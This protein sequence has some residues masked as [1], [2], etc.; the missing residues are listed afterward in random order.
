MGINATIKKENLIENSDIDGN[1]LVIS[2]GKICF[3]ST[4][5][6]G[7][8]TYLKSAG[9]IENDKIPLLGVNSD[10]TRRTGALL[11]KTINFDKK[12]EIIP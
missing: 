11:N 9:I 7:D 10:P 6:G 5:V 12:D 4:S 8:S 2:V 1:D 3:I